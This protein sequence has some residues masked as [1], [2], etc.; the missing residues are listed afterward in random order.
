M[1]EKNII[2]T[3]FGLYFC[4]H[5]RSIAH[6]KLKNAPNM[7]KNLNGFLRKFRLKPSKSTPPKSTPPKSILSK[8]TLLFPAGFTCFKWVIV[9]ISIPTATAI[10]ANGEKTVAGHARSG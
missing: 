10:A 9:V 1:C 3:F 4:K 2:H 5:Q 7:L 6:L 8:S